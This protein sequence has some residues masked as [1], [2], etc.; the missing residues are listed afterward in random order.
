[1]LRALRDR[2]TYANVV[3]TLALFV[4]LGGSSYAAFKI[5]GR[6]IRKHSLTGRLFK[7][8]SVG[9]RAIKERSLR[10]V[11]RARNAAR[12]DGVTAERL[13]VR[14]PQGTVPVSDV[15]VETQARPPA[16]YS[17]AAA[18]CEI[19][20]NKAHP[21][22]RLPTHEELMTAIGA[23]GITLAS[24]G[25]LTSNVYPP[26]TPEERL[27]VLYILDNTGNVGVTSDTAAGAKAFRCVADPVN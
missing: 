6:D 13:L 24:G 5:T 23:Y 20:D 2:L 18:A 4:A 7:A 26:K 27:Q 19:T 9:G 25:E 3:A 15:C 12:L 21:G 1:M 14:C 17:S 10:T 11:P 16:P 22:R 8:N